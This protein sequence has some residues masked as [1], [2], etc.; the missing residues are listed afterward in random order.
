MQDAVL[1]PISEG[2]QVLLT[3][4]RYELLATADIERKIAICSI[5]HDCANAQR[6]A[7]CDVIPGASPSLPEFSMLIAEIPS[8]LNN[9][10]T[11][12]PLLAILDGFTTKPRASKPILTAAIRRAVEL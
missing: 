3:V 7:R 4:L 10:R 8:H 1:G 6:L 12:A 9:K 5:I 2:L 11:L